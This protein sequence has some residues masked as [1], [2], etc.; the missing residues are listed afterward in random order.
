TTGLGV[1]NVT[2][3]VGFSYSKNAIGNATVFVNGKQ[4][5][6]TQAGTY[7]CTLEGYSPIETFD[8]EA[9]TAGYEQATL[10]VSTLQESNTTLYSLI[11]ASIL[12]TIA[13]VLVKRRDKTQ[14][15]N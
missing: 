4:C 3:H 6:E 14:K 2:V 8:I 10:T 7:T 9:N 1:T 5:N 15:L 12:V 11:I 13:F